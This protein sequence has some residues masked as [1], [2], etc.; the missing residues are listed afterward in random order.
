VLALPS[1][2]AA[3]APCLKAFYTWRHKLLDM[4]YIRVPYLSDTRI[5]GKKWTLLE[6]VVVAVL[7]IGERKYALRS[8]LTLFLYG[9]IAALPILSTGTLA[10]LLTV[11]A[12]L[13]AARNNP[14]TLVGGVP[15]E[16]ALAWH[17]LAAYSTFVVV[18]RKEGCL[19]RACYV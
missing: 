11:A 6:A 8:A 10:S 7:L 1:V 4:L 9:G 17:K 18:S 14:L 12:L 16:R 5:M 15:F 2:S 13:L 19:V 3:T